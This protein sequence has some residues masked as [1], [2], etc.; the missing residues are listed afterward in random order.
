MAILSCFS[1]VGQTEIRVH[2]ADKCCSTNAGVKLSSTAIEILRVDE[3]WWSDKSETMSS[4]Q[5]SSAVSDI[6]NMFKVDQ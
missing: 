6:L 1:C 2:R 4:R 3:S 5:L